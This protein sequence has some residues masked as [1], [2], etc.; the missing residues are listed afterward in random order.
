M[1][2]CI[3]DSKT[4]TWSMLSSGGLAMALQ[5][6][7]IQKKTLMTSFKRNKEKKTGNIKEI[8]NKKYEISK[9]N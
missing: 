4:R 3:Y 7:R 9:N 2:T 5:P 1:C 8:Q 6:V